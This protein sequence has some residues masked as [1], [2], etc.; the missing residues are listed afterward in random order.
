MVHET[1]VVA[2]CGAGWALVTGYN[3]ILESDVILDS[4]VSVCSSKM[5]FK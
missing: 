1:S 4:D 2:K 3:W 5:S